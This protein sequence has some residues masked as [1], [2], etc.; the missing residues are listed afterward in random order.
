MRPQIVHAN[1]ADEFRT[2]ERCCI[3]ELWNRKDD[4]GVSIA[5]ARVEAGVATQP[6][7]LEG[8]TERYL[9]VAGAGVV[10][11]EGLPPEKVGP[12][13][14]VLIPDGAVQWIENTGSSDL[15]FYAICTPRF[16]PE[17]YRDRSRG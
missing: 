8:I 12:G 2:D 1:E 11:V 13:D 17:A 7:S 9:I 14:L 4:A 3:L 16:S 10:N 15:G 6:H 5:R